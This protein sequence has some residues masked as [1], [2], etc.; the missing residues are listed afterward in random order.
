MIIIIFI[1]TEILPPTLPANFTS[2]PELLRQISTAILKTNVTFTS[3]VTVTIRGIGGIGKSTIAKAVCYEQSINDSF[4][5][6]FLWISLTPP[7]NVT[8]ELCKI[9]N[10]LTNQPIESNQ[11]FVK[12]KIKGHLNSNSYKLLVILDDV[13]N[14]EDALPYVEVFCSCKILL[15]TRKSVINSKIP[16]NNP[17]DIKP[18]ELD[19][20]VKLL[21]SRIDAFETLDDSAR[22]MVYKLAEYLYCWPLLLNLVRTQLYI[23]CTE[24]K[25]SLN[26]AM[27]LATQ[28][29]SKSF[30]VFDEA[31]REKAVK[32]CLDTSLNLLPEQ[33]TRVLHSVILTIGGLGPYA[34]KDSVAR[35]SK[36]S[37][38]QFSTCVTNLWSHGL[39]ELIDVPAYPTNHHISCIGVHHIVAHYITETMP[40][41]QLYEKIQSVVNFD[42]NVYDDISEPYKKENEITSS[43]LGISLLHMI[44]QVALSLFR[45]TSVLACVLER[46]FSD[47]DNSSNTITDELTMENRYGKMNRDSALIVSFL[48]DNKHS[49]A[50]ECVDNHYKTHPVLRMQ[51]RFPKNFLLDGKCVALED[52][53]GVVNLTV[54]KYLIPYITFHKCVAVLLKLKASNEDICHLESS[55]IFVY[56]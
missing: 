56:L 28:K 25:M 34:V 38:E 49:D 53:A 7:H 16:T 18:M 17:I 40:V 41:E 13:W 54:Y 22:V 8:E 19:E 29:L 43:N 47:F 4:T 2:R 44:P 6:G 52:V 32:I 33:D 50:V 39:I 36:I 42:V 30:T 26:K 51:K 3:E 5:D 1:C 23:Y 14:A 45:L 21:T 46:M 31:S 11:S 27:V 9:Y 37:F 15:T 10:K 55:F 24:W 35:A 20:A 48:A 12:E